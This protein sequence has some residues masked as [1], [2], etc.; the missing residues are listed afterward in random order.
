MLTIDL[1]DLLET[2]ESIRKEIHPDLDS[3]FLAAVVRAEEENP[4]D[5]A[6]AIRRIE[7]ALK[8]VLAK[9]S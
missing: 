7:T 1:K 3:T 4:E 9:G 5:D 6:E 8:T 2:V